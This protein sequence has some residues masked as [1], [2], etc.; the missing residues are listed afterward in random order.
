MTEKSKIQPNKRESRLLYK[1][2]AKAGNTAKAKSGSPSFKDPVGQ[3]HFLTHF[4]KR[5]APATD[6]MGRDSVF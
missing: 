5:I 6:L 1:A 2:P 3:S 4:S